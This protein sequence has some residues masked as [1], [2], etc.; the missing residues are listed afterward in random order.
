MRRRTALSI[1]GILAF[2]VSGC[3]G[4]TS[5]PG[6]QSLP[7][8]LFE[9]SRHSD[10][11]PAGFDDGVKRTSCGDITLTQGESPS[12]DGV[13]CM[14]AAI[15]SANAELAVIA[16]TTEGDPIV[17]FYRT[18]PGKQGFEMFVNGTF[19][20]YGA[21]E[22]AHLTCPGADISTPSGCVDDAG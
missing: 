21:G 17:T 7:D 4:V 10:A 8:N 18:A 20:R 16:P 1:A 12:A 9:A 3:A 14:N 22:W 11:A 19:D 5:F 6:P 2:T 13:D 15:G